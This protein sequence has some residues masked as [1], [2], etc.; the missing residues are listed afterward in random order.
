MRSN[1]IEKFEHWRCRME[2]ASKKKQVKPEEVP[3]ITIEEMKA[4][5][6]S[7]AELLIVDNQPGGVYEEGHI[8]GAIWIPWTMERIAWEDAQKLPLDKN[9][10]IVTYCDCG[11]GES[12]SADMAARL[13]RMGFRN[14]KVLADP[15]IKGWR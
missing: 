8:E 1:R 11:P 4:L 2:D 13:I 15:S 5:I 6:E 12:T 9:K 3:R 10:M 14:A 7:G